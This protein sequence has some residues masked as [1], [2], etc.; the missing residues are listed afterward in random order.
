MVETFE[1]KEGNLTKAHPNA[2]N[3]YVIPSEVIFIEA[4]AFSLFSKVEFSISFGSNSLVT[5][6]G[7]S[8]F[9]GCTKLISIDFSN[10]NNLKTI[11]NYAFY[12]CEALTSLSFPASL[13]VLGFYGSFNNCKNLISVTF[14]EDCKIRI[15]ETGTFKRTSIKRFDV[16]ASCTRI[17]G[18]SFAFTEVEWFTVNEKNGCYKEYN[19]SVFNSDLTALVIHRKS[20]ELSLPPTAKSIESISLSAFKGDIILNN[21]ISSFQK[22]SFMGY[23]G[24]NIAIY[25]VFSSINKRMFEDCTKLVE[26]KFYNKVDTIESESF[27]RCRSLRRI[28]FA[29]QV[30][31]I[32]STAFPNINRICFSGE[33]ANIKALIPNKYIHECSLVNTCKPNQNRRASQCSFLI[34]F[35]LTSS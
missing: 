32:V 33:I 2:G 26:V 28:V 17:S 16:P 24:R 21:N 31:S 29:Y 23:Q 4:N 12:S 35:V 15:I 19:G 20:G 8:A 1:I 25:G 14:P 30:Q 10:A 6:I 18:E 27:V 3:A 5:K 34:V 13:E 7:T 11:D 22:W 9:S